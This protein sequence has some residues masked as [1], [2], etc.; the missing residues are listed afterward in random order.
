MTKRISEKYPLGTLHDI[1]L[2][3]LQ[4]DPEQPRKHFADDA[5]SELTNSIKKHGILQPI[6]F[7]VE[8]DKLIIV[9]GERR[10][11]ATKKAGL[12]TI[13]AVRVEKDFAL[14]A[15]A[16]NMTRESLTAMEE[17]EALQKVIDTDKIKQIDLAKAIGKAEST[18]SEILKLN[19]LSDTIKKTARTDKRWTRKLLLRLAAQTDKKKQ[20][21]SFYQAK[22]RIEQDKPVPKKKATEENVTEMYRTKLNS[23]IIALKK[24]KEENQLELVIKPLEPEIVELMELLMPK[25]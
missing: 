9:A 18:V 8:E 2:N 19:T 24:T 20:Y 21:A 14:I 3:M 13:P 6:L 22:K 10:W 11:R 16:E 15:L 23:L 4:A 12:K 5:L 7:R 25:E 1:P 17:A